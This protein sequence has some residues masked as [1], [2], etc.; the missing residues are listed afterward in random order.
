MRRILLVFTIFLAFIG[1]SQSMGDFRTAASGNW[2]A[3]STWEMWNG[4]SWGGT[5]VTPGAMSA[6][7]NVTIQNGHSV[8]LTSTP[9]F[10]IA[11][12]TIGGGTSGALGSDGS[13]RTLNI[14]GNLVINAGG[15]LN[16]GPNTYT[17]SGTTTVAGTISDN[18]GTGTN[19]FTGLVTITSTGNISTTN[20]SPFTF[21]GGIANSGVFSKGGT[22]T[23]TLTNTQTITANAATSIT[24]A[25]TANAGAHITYA[26]TNT[27]TLGGTCTYNGNLITSGTVSVVSAGTT[28]IAGNYTLGSGT[29]YTISG[30]AFTVSGTSTIDGSFVDNNAN[31][32]DTFIGKITIGSTGKWDTSPINTTANLHIR[33]DFENQHTTASEIIFNNVR[34]YGGN[35]TISSVVGLDFGDIRIGNAG[36]PTTP[37]NLVITFNLNVNIKTGLTGATGSVYFSEGIAKAG[38]GFYIK[39]EA[40]TNGASATNGWVTGT[41]KRYMATGAP[42]PTLGIGTP[43]YYNPLTL[44]TTAVTVAGDFTA[45]YVTGDHPNIATSCLNAAKSDNKYLVYSATATFTRL[46]LTVGITAAE[47]DGG[48][49]AASLVGGIYTGAKWLYPNINGTPSTSVALRGASLASGQIQLAEVNASYTVPGDPTV[50]GNGVWNGYAYNS[51]NFTNYRGYFTYNGLGF[52]TRT[53]DSYAV[54]GDPYV[55]SMVS[56]YQGCTYPMDNFT[57]SFKRTN[58]PTAYYQLDYNGHD[59]GMVAYLNGVLIANANKPTFNAAAETALWVGELNASSQLEFRWNEGGGGHYTSAVLTAVTPADLTAG[60]IYGNQSFCSSESVIK[61]LTSLSVGTTGC[62]SLSYQWQSSLDNSVW[63][64]IAGATNTTYLPTGVTQTTYYRRKALDACNRVAYT[65]TITVNVYGSAPGTPTVYGDGQWIAYAYGAN[66]FTSYKGYFT[67]AA[68]NFDTRTTDLVGNTTSTLNMAN[69]FQGCTMPI[70]NFSVRF[71]RTNIPAGDYQIDL[72]GHDDQLRIYKNGSLI[73]QNN[74]Y[75]PGAEP[76]AWTGSILATDLIDIEWVDGTGGHFATFTMTLLGSTPSA[77]VPGVISQNQTICTGDYPI[78]PLTGT[79]ATGGCNVV[80]GYGTTTIYS[81]YQWE[82]SY[83]GLNFSDITGATAQ[84]YTAPSS[85][86]FN[87]DTWY[88]RRVTDQCGRVDY[89]NSIK[90][91]IDNSSYGTPSVYPSNEWRV[92]SYKDNAFGTYAGYFPVATDSY[93]SQTYYTSAQ[94]PYYA[95]TYLG[96]TVPVTN[97]ST[98][99][100]RKGFTSGI[101]QIMV[102]HDNEGRLLM[103]G[104]QVYNVTSIVSTPVSVWVGPLNSNSQIDWRFVG[105]GSPNSTSI[106]VNPFTPL[107][108]S[109]GTIDGDKIV[110]RGDIPSPFTSLTLSSGGCYTDPTNYYWQY[111]TNSGSS[112]ITLAS[113]QGIG[114]TPVQTIFA[115]TW[116]RRAV[117]DVCGNIAYSNIAKVTLNNTPPGNPSIFPSNQWNAYVYDDPDWGSYIGYFSVANTLDFD[118]RN[119]YCNTCAPSVASVPLANQG[120]S[121]QGCQNVATNVGVKMRRQGVTT[122]GYYQIDLPYYDDETRLYV[123]GTLVFSNPT[124]YNNTPS[125]NVWT[126]YLDGS[127]TIDFWYQNDNGPGGA[128]IKFNYLGVTA[129]TG[130]LGGSIASQY[131]TYCINDLPSFTSVT[132]ASGACYPTYVWQYSLDNSVWNDITSATSASYSGLLPITSL[133]Y[134]RRKASDV[135]ANGPVY[136]NTITINPS[137]SAAGNPSVFGNG[138][139]NAYVYASNVHAAPTSYVG[140]YTE[141]SLSFN[142]T[143]KFATTLAPSVST[144]YQGCQTSGT[145][146]TVA[147]K[148]T[149]FTAGTYQID[150]NTH[151]DYVTLVVNGVTVFNHNAC[152]DAHNNVWTGILGPS[153]Q[154]ELRYTNNSGPGSLQ[155]TFTTVTPT[156]MSSAGTVAGAQTVCNGGTPTALTEAAAGVSGCYVYYQ[157]QSSTDNATFVDISGATSNA[158]TP[159][160]ITQ[161]TYFRRKAIDACNNVDYSNTLTVTPLPAV[162]AGTAGVSGT[163]CATASVPLTQ[164]VAASGG[165]GTYTYQW[166]SSLDNITYSNIGGATSANYTVPS[167]ATSTYYRRQVSSCGATVNGNV[168][169]LQLGTGTAIAQQPP[170]T[171]TVCSGATASIGLVATGLNVTYQWQYFTGGSY[172]VLSNTGNYSGVSTN[173]LQIANVTNPSNTGNYRCVVSGSCSP[174]TV[175][176]NVVAVSIGGPTI[177]VQPVNT[178]VCQNSDTVLTV[179]AS[180]SLTYQWEE[181]T[182]SGS[183]WGPL[184]NTGI[185]SGVT[186]SKL[187]FTNTTGINNNQY[188][189]VVTSSCGSTTSATATIT[190]Q[191]P[192]ASNTLTGGTVCAGSNLTLTGNAVTSASYQW[193]L[194]NAGVYTAISGATGQ[195][196][197][198]S[199]NTSQNYKR[200]VTVATC[201]N[202]SAVLAVT[203]ASAYAITT[204]PATTTTQCSGTATISVVATNVTSYQWQ[205]STDGGTN[206][207]SVGASG[208][209]SGVTTNTLSI[210]VN[211]SLSGNRYRIRLTGCNGTGTSNS[212]LL[213]SNTTLSYTTHPTNTSSCINGSTTMSVVASANPSGATMTYKWQ[214]NLGSATGNAFVD[215]SSNSVVFNYTTATITIS[216][217]GLSYNGAQFRCITSSACASSSVTSNVATLTVYDAITGNGISTAQSI[218]NGEVP[219]LLMGSNPPTGG[220]GVFTYQWLQSTGGG[221]ANISGATSFDYQ[222]AALTTTT[223]YERIAYSGNCQAVTS[224]PIQVLVGAATSVVTNP[225]DANTCAGTNA[226]FTV[227]GGGSALQYQWQT[228][229]GT[230]TF[231]NITDVVNYSGKTTATLTVITPSFA[232]NGY[233]YRVVINGNCLPENVTSAFATLNLSSAPVITTQPSFAGNVCEDASTTVSVAASGT[234]LSYQWQSKTGS[235]SFVNIVA[236]SPYSNETTSTLSINPVSAALNSTQYRCVVTQSS[237]SVNSNAATLPVIN[238][239]SITMHPTDRTVCSGVNTSMTATATGAGLTYQWQMTPPSTFTNVSGVL[240][241]G[242]AQPT[243]QILAPPLASNGKSFRIRVSGTCTP[244][245]IFS[246][247]AVLTVNGAGYWTGATDTDWNNNSNWCVAKPTSADDVTLPNGLTN[248]PVVSSSSPLATAKSIVIATNAS[249]TITSTNEL[250]VHGNWNNNGTFVSNLSTVNFTSS[251]PQAIGGITKSVFNH[252]KIT[253]THAIGMAVNTDIKVKSTLEL[254]ANTLVNAGSNS[255]ILLSD[256]SGTAR[257]LPVPATSSYQGNLSMQRYIPAKRAPRYVAVPVSGATIAQFKDSVVIAGSTAG[258]FDSPNTSVSTFKNYDETRATWDYNKGWVSATSVNQALNVGSGYYLYV[259]G[260]RTTVFPSAEAVTLQVKGSPQ[261]GNKTL[262]LTYSASGIKGWNLIGNPYPSQI[263]W[264]SPNITKTNIDNALYTWDATAT[265]QGQYYSYVNGVASPAKAN[266]SIIPSMNGFF[267]KANT[268]GASVSFTENA[269][270]GTSNYSVFRKAQIADLLRFKLK[271]NG[272]VDDAVVYYTDHATNRFN[273]EVDALKMLNAELNIYTYVEGDLMS[274][275]AISKSDDDTIAIPLVVTMKTKGAFEIDFSE[276]R[277]SEWHDLYLYDKFLNTHVPLIQGNSYLAEQNDAKGSYATDR[278]LITNT[279]SSSQVI[280]SNMDMEFGSGTLTAYPNPLKGEALNISLANFKSASVNIE[281]LSADGVKVYSGVVLNNKVLTLDVFKQLSSGIYILKAMDADITKQIHIAKIN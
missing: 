9:G 65:N 108:L 221:Y 197:T 62:S 176:S 89:S 239:P 268:T 240:Y 216:N 126:G 87:L 11:N 166:Q 185:Y 127:S 257:L 94:S 100:K 153:S 177:A 246:N 53:S 237:C 109:G 259:P 46:D 245:G 159:T 152:C 25:I 250:D 194:D 113:S 267:V 260:K 43:T 31:G 149:N 255:I 114:Y 90:I 95:A 137:G 68:L 192:I 273:K 27:L 229:N 106:S 103:D 230:G 203:P 102:K 5:L 238:K 116:Y 171:Y 36:T 272:A 105:G 77:L 200:R 266:P 186:T 183:T 104:N 16:F 111:S 224:F 58:F 145:N 45:A 88:R 2:N 37:T 91:T 156:G 48:T 212:S 151:D 124:W 169:Y 214:Y 264:D 206:Y 150:I 222:P 277:L 42:S 244:T 219:Q 232:Y 209:Y 14:T 208:V 187:K 279:L 135:C 76:N 78:I 274:I 210:N 39:A 134:Y 188:R 66:N 241:S 269:K 6:G 33:G 213:I 50:Y 92:Y 218:C 97:Y 10:S 164:T 174:T 131:S 179:I 256:A 247:P 189:C 158:Y 157:W 261:I 1:Y 132:P 217:P 278:F 99:V 83:D 253:N 170:A 8:T 74:N 59:D 143:N 34:F 139:W 18:S 122:N 147:Y 47:L 271:A 85:P 23:V 30:N 155:A 107:T 172:V 128:Y 56:T 101:Y 40:G 236:G 7:A 138:T 175:T 80:P 3:T 70:D 163:Y 142:T 281:I 207:S 196:H 133:V 96:C 248:Y 202:L 4:F 204:Q 38:T 121:Y 141:S 82:T 148:R 75:T 233:K 227:V 161:V 182:N 195:N 64:D 57:V 252:L 144:G 220:N 184:S 140:Y 234:G 231:T 63:T 251:S 60:S 44:A 193:Y 228:D 84:N 115:E 51:T 136:S 112:W 15:G 223:N 225:T 276:I 226:T 211:P 262:N 243:L 125:V 201:T 265:G 119:Y 180:G 198:I 168:V 13:V 258:G 86:T 73:F 17:I 22:G 26:G 41:F 123:N 32:V 129:P 110:C 154:V 21:G 98:S 24:S 270:V 235:G 173:T 199:V 130:L 275:N 49:T 165:N 205:I 29:S 52:D 162:T 28:T 67:Y 118:T 55:L 146:Y 72:N 120:L 117:L 181:S 249:L 20:N 35:N 69:T 191:S 19:T 167:F 160:S 79:A 54:N 71:R 93:D 12:L 254:G 190:I 215:I 263:D 81:G 61:T 178:T 242:G 280:T